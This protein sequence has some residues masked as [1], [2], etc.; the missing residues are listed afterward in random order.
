MVDRLNVKTTQRSIVS[1][2]TR[3]Y[4]TLIFELPTAFVIDLSGEAEMR[5]LQQ[6][7]WTSYD[8]WIY[9][10]NDAANALYADA[11][12]ARL[13]GGIFESPLL[14]QYA[15]TTISSA[16]FANPWPA[17]GLPT[18]QQV[19]RLREDLHTLQT[20]L[21]A[22]RDVVPLDAASDPTIADGGISAERDFLDATDQRPE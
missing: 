15:G 13:S 5:N 4:E 12:F 11:S 1:E 17:L 3:F 19:Q 16:I 22:V 9:V 10:P 20:D 6:A 21:Q 18:A 2:V 7:A 8:S 14:I